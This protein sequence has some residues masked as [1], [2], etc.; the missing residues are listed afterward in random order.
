MVVKEKVVKSP[1]LGILRK[2]GK[3]SLYPNNYVIM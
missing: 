3:K 2:N 1:S